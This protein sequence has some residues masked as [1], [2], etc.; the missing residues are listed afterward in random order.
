MLCKERHDHHQVITLNILSANVKPVPTGSRFLSERVTCR[1]WNTL[2]DELNYDTNCLNSFRSALLE[3]YHKSLEV[4]YNP[5]NP[6]T[7]K[8]MPEM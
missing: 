4:N 6:R 2:V 7:F 8:T 3:Y 5:D 1:I